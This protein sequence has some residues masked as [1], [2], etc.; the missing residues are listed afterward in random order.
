M[1]GTVENLAEKIQALSPEQIAEVEAFVDSLRLRAQDCG[2]SRASAEVSAP[3][4][5]AV[6]SNPEDDIYDV[7]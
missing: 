7:L 2:L 6:W 1:N 5:A 4:F 3:A